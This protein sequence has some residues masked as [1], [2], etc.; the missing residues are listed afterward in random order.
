MYFLEIHRV[1]NVTN[2]WNNFEQKLVAFVRRVFREAIFSLVD[3][4]YISV[5]SI[6]VV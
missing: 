1:K 4:V 6:R 2:T 3:Q 5:F